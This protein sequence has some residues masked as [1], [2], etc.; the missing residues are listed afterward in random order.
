MVNENSG[1]I[2]F[3]QRFYL[4]N[5]EPN[6]VLCWHLIIIVI[7]KPVKLM[8]KF[9]P[10]K[11]NLDFVKKIFFRILCTYLW[12]YHF[13]KTIWLTIFEC[14]FINFATSPN[15]FTDSIIWT[16]I[17]FKV[18]YIQTKAVWNKIDHWPWFVLTWIGIMYFLP[19][20]QLLYFCKG[21]KSI[22]YL[23][24]CPHCCGCMFQLSLLLTQS[25][26]WRHPLVSNRCNDKE[27][28]KGDNSIVQCSQ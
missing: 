19:R 1:S 7:I 12:I 27:T 14:S 23:H 17:Y 6:K 5:S 3:D 28:L 21:V 8:A 26:Q 10:N 18:A 22:F 15:I 25:R 16:L 20:D 4:P 2:G 13:A 11:S 24:K 9:S